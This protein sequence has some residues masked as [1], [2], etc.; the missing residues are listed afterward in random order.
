MKVL[1]EDK[2]LLERICRWDDASAY[3]KL[4][5]Q[6]YP[7]LVAYSELIVEHTE[8]ED[9]VQTLMMN[10]WGR[11]KSLNIGDSISSYLFVS[12]R[13]ACLN[14]VKHASVQSRAISDL[15]LSLI[16]S[17]ADCSAYRSNEIFEKMQQALDRLPEAQR[18]LLDS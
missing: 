1:S 17:A 15:R 10:L 14:A 8:A 16:D 3:R 9:I 4:Y 2:Y 13:N 6:Y 5:K 11:R 7:S 12:A 18:Q